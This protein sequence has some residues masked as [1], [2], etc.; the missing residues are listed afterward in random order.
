MRFALIQWG[1]LSAAAA[2]MLLVGSP[3]KA[4]D[5]M[6]VRTVAETLGARAQGA[7]AE[8]DGQ[9]SKLS[10]SAVRVLMTYAVSIIP[11][12]VNGPD[13]KRIKVDKSEPGKFLIPVD[14]ARAVIRVAT[15][16]AYAEAC[17]LPDLGRANYQ[18]LITGEE[19]RKI[20][21]AD[22]LMF[23]KALHM[24][25]VSYFTG[26]IQINEA[27]ETEPA[28]GDAQGQ[29]A[30]A[31]AAPAPSSEPAF[32]PKKPTCS[33]EQKQK[34]TQAINSYVQS[35]SAAPDGGAKPAPGAN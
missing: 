26:N 6:D 31:G 25:A 19:G 30:Q 22:Q 28:A 4:A 1:R 10:D 14:E 27:P 29:E 3:L 15:R 12:N 5:N 17:G 18:T 9:K 2:V 32:T 11:D 8:G 33:P 16:T 21:S 24:F 23:I 35:A 13:G 34:V 7:G 20:W